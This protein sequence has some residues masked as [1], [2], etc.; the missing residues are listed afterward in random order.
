MHRTSAS[1]PEPNVEL[2]PAWEPGSS[3]ND[4]VPP[5]SLSTY[6]CRKIDGEDDCKVCYIH[7]NAGD[8]NELLKGI[9]FSRRNLVTFS[10]VDVERNWVFQ[11][12]WRTHRDPPS[13][14]KWY[15][16]GKLDMDERKVRTWSTWTKLYVTKAAAERALSAYSRDLRASCLLRA[17]NL[18]FS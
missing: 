1:R 11:R 6:D 14:Q 18:S 5:V 13:A 7:C 17:R 3:N 12:S 15:S 10:S 16:A 9:G 4:F 2:D 8:E